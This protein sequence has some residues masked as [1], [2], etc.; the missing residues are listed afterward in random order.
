MRS[1][2][3]SE[4]GHEILSEPTEGLWSRLKVKGMER[5]QVKSSTMVTVSGTGQ[6]FQK[7]N[8]REKS[9]NSGLETEPMLR[10]KT[11]AKGGCYPRIK[12]P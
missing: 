8:Q 5:K 10:E 11:L 7:S 12:M 3:G 6:E 2:R 4:I 9:E 1:K